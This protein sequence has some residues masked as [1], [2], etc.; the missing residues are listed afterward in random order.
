MSQFPCAEGF[1]FSPAALPVTSPYDFRIAAASGI[2]LPGLMER[3]QQLNVPF[4]SNAYINARSC[5]PAVPGLPQW[6]APRGLPMMDDTV[7]Q[8]NVFEPYVTEDVNTYRDVLTNVASTTTWVPDSAGII[9][10]NAQ[11][12]ATDPRMLGIDYGLPYLRSMSQNQALDQN[13]PNQ[14]F[15][16]EFNAMMGN[17]RNNGGKSMDSKPSNWIYIGPTI[18]IIMFI[19]IIVLLIVFVR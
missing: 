3:T 11:M 4:D 8:F 19:V 7:N 10:R 13:S 12:L 2:N 16:Q 5:C 18:G 6:P 1:A 14:I 15:A 9:Q 17:V